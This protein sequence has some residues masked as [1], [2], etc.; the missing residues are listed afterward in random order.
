MPLDRLGIGKL[1]LPLEMDIN[2]RTALEEF[3]TR[4]D[5]NVNYLLAE[6]IALKARVY[7]LEHP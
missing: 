6:N 7:T 5:D 4:V 3:A 1:T 2:T